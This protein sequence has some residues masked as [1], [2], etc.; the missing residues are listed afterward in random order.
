MEFAGLVRLI[1]YSRRTSRTG[2]DY[3]EDMVFPM[4]QIRSGLD[5]AFPTSDAELAVTEIP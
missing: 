1:S 5:I 4:S 3:A 2:A